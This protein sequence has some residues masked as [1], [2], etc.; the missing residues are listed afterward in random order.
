M[1]RRGFIKRIGGVAADALAVATIPATAATD[2]YTVSITPKGLESTS[3]EIESFANLFGVFR[4][5][6]TDDELAHYL[7]RRIINDRLGY[8]EQWLETEINPPMK[9]RNEPRF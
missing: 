3:F 1:T 2:I 9:I 8:G 7:K 5:G 4:N 6:R